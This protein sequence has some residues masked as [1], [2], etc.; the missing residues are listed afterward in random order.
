MSITAELQK[1]PLAMSVISH[2]GIHRY[3]EKL[4]SA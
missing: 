2:R 3:A 4:Q 1:K